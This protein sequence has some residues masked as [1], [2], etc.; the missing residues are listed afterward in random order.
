MLPS[1]GG[2]GRP[3]YSYQGHR[4]QTPEG[5]EKEC[6]LAQGWRWQRE[7]RMTG[8][9][10]HARGRGRGRPSRE[11]GLAWEIMASGGVREGGYVHL[12]PQDRT[13]VGC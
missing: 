13:R 11:E 4:E 1:E 12:R 3:L 8:S 5:G 7:R 6:M 9:K 10:N 2:V